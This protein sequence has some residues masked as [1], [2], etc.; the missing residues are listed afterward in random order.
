MN[1]A[2]YRESPRPGPF[3]IGG[4][5]VLGLYLAATALVNLWQWRWFDYFSDSPDLAESVVP[6]FPDPQ[7][8][9][10]TR[11]VLPNTVVGVPYQAGAYVIDVALPA[12]LTVFYRHHRLSQEAR[13]VLYT[14]PL[15]EQ[16]RLLANDRGRLLLDAGKEPH[17]LLTILRAGRQP[18]VAARLAPW[19]LLE[20][21]AARE[22]QPLLRLEGGGGE[23]VGFWS[24]SQG[25]RTIIGREY[26]LPRTGSSRLALT[27]FHEGRVVDLRFSFSADDPD[28]LALVRAW[29][30]GIDPLT[31]DEA[32]MK[33]CEK[34]TE[35][36]H[37]DPALWMC[38]KLVTVAHW[39][40]HP[41]DVT[42]AASLVDCYREA[43]DRRGLQVVREQLALLK[44]EDAPTR[45]L[46]ADVDA[47][48]DELERKH[49]AAPAESAPP[50]ASPEAN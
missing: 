31:A 28:N 15:W 3:L 38:R 41:G 27:V 16:R 35:S 47:A 24:L 30:E 49:E 13:V 18:A 32:S 43:K 42:A 12:E 50:P 4:L 21:A 36:N 29:L 33:R 5:V 8:L 10:R 46:L 37:N 1:L 6:A 25:P 19:L 20:W 44:D 40:D 2:Y 17:E 23:A 11:V 45:R 48:L 34:W 7:V 9:H 26:R 22:L 14:R 39:L